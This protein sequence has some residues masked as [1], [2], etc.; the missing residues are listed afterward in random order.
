MSKRIKKP[1]KPEPEKVLTYREKLE[2]KEFKHVFVPDGNIIEVTVLS[3]VWM[4]ELKN[5]QCL[6]MQLDYDFFMAIEYQDE[7]NPIYRYGFN[8]NNILINTTKNKDNG[9]QS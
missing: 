6:A 5:K 7:Q 9:K 3:C 8:S 4:P 1:V 2:L